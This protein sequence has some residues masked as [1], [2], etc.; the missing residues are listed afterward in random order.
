MS[1]DRSYPFNM[2]PP[3]NNCRAIK[4]DGHNCGRPARR[5]AGDTHPE[6]LHF[7]S[8]HKRTYATKFRDAGA[9]HHAEGRCFEVT[10][11]RWCINAADP[12][13][14][15][16]GM[17]RE[18]TERL[19]ANREARAELR[20]HRQMATELLVALEGQIPP[21]TWQAAAQAMHGMDGVPLRVREA[22]ARGF[23]ENRFGRWGIFPF[24]NYW[25][26]LVG[27]RVGPEPVPAAPQPPPPA[28][29][30][31]P[32]VAPVRDLARL[33][34]DK[35]NVHTVAVTDQTNKA[36]E[37]LLAVEVSKEQQTEKTL[38]LVWL[39]THV[40]TKVSY[41]TFLT[42]SADINKWFNTKDCRARD[43]T[44]YRR[45]LRGLVALITSEKDD[46]RKEEM[47]RRCWEECNESVGMCCEGHISRLCNVLV[48]F[49]EAFQPPVPFGEILQ[50][51]MAAIAGLDVTEEEKRKQANAFFDEHK[52]PEA[53]RTA[54]LEAF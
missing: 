4:G 14:L 17:H 15:H 53:D 38:A 51:K 29:P 48:G 21:P 39:R 27:G 5:E 12:G 40:G 9:T 20:E 25:A 49:D 22:V 36:T 10:G 50:G 11:G 41:S 52:V 37:K 45:L 18:R 8:I 31:A 2:P 13:H 28:A 32:P 34:R 7:C 35:Q 30:A 24:A 33:A 43:D 42:V 23:Y 16:C 44:L 19:V 6:H 26:W 1:K 54:W 46:E 3:E 47:F